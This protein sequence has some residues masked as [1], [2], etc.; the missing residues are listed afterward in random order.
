M[1]ED[2][3]ALVLAGG[4]SARMGQD[5]AMLRLAPEGPT[6]L[7]AAI[8]RFRPL[9]GEVL[10]SVRQPYAGLGIRQIADEAKG[11][12]PLAGLVAGL[13]AAQR[14]WVFAVAVDMP[15]VQA[16]LVEALAARRGAHEAVVPRVDG[17][18]QPLCAFYA[19]S[20]QAAFAATLAAPGKHSLHESL[21]R[22]DTCFVEA[23]A[24]RSDDPGLTGFFD[25]DTPE[26]FARAQ[27][28]FQED[29]PCPN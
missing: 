13:A 10:A 2:C 26:A 21:A 28:I 15:F 6:L 25:L 17:R 9:F 19:K 27:K 1:L 7:E 4:N 5:K 23:D 22:L 18:P 29:F 8:A 16:G 24:L 11:Q 3:T 20:A 14:P 12:G